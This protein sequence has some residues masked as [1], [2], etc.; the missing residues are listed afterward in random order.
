[1]M[2]WKSI[3]LSQMSSTVK[4]EQPLRQARCLSRSESCFS[5]QFISCDGLWT[6]I[7]MTYHEAAEGRPVR[8]VMVCVARR[9]NE[10]DVS[11]PK[12]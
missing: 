9:P 7:V 5:R 2:P 4:C 1:M 8:E 11:I 10:A 3:Y 12:H 6:E